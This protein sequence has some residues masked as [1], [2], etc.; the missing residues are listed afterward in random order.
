MENMTSQGTRNII[1]DQFN[2]DRKQHMDNLLSKTKNQQDIKINNQNNI[3]NQTKYFADINQNLH[4]GSN[5][6]LNYIP[7]ENYTPFT[8]PEKTENKNTKTPLVTN[9]M[10]LPKFSGDEKLNI[11]NANLPF[12]K[13]LSD[14]IVKNTHPKN[15]Y[16]DDPNS[17]KLISHRL[18]Q[19]EIETNRIIPPVITTNNYIP[20]IGK[21]RKLSNIIYNSFIKM[22]NSYQDK[23]SEELIQDLLERSNYNNGSNLNKDNLY[24]LIDNIK[25]TIVSKNLYTQDINNDI[26]EQETITKSFI[27]TIDSSDRY[28]KN[29]ELPNNYKIDFGGKKTESDDSNENYQYIDQIFRNVTSVELIEAIIPKFTNKNVPYILIEIEELGSNFF[30]SNSFL[31]SSFA[32]LTRP[33]I[34]GDYLYYKNDTNIKSF[35]P[36]IE[37]Q[38]LTF[39]FR[40]NKGNLLN[41]QSDCDS[42]M[43]ENFLTLKINCIQRDLNS[44]FLQKN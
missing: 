5:N 37:I 12:N 4:I 25:N 20:E 21:K 24:Q 40:D 44:M 18:S 38:G 16:T 27:I 36:R 2:M 26:F 10:P 43:L 3:Q 34:N 31:S 19:N 42:N 15:I 13:K 8:S 9:F 23:V 32:K 39:K 41:F 17:K 33:E 1:K 30:G 14:N 7:T 29:W 6:M 11:N 28:K 22:Y 35:S